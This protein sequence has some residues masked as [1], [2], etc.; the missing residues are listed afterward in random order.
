MVYRLKSIRN[1]FRLCIYYTLSM[2]G[3]VLSVITLIYFHLNILQKLS[4]YLKLKDVH[5]F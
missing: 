5:F 2:L 1:L 3:L 4:E